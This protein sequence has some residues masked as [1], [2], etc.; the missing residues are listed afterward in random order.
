MNQQSSKW[1]VEDRRFV[2]SIMGG[3]SFSSGEQF[4][5]E[6]EAQEKLTVPHK[7]HRCLE[8]YNKPTNR[9]EKTVESAWLYK[10][11][12][13]GP[14]T[15]LTKLFPMEPG[16]WPSFNPSHPKGWA[17]NVRPCAKV[18][19]H[20]IWL[21]LTVLSPSRFGRQDE[22]AQSQRC[23]KKNPTPRKMLERKYT[24]FV[25]VL[26]FLGGCLFVLFVCGFGWGFFVNSPHVEGNLR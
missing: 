10:T 18:H 21:V 22:W 26:S 5:Q 3:F 2:L 13:S 7:W 8:N 17:W 15:C 24:S 14:V 16:G 25:L 6:Q 4:S 1:R 19:S 9:R 11:H 20:N 23:F 12:L